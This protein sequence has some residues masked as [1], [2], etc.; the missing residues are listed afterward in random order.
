MWSSGLVAGKAITAMVATRR[1]GAR[2]TYVSV[3]AYLF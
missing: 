3:F 1:A 2:A